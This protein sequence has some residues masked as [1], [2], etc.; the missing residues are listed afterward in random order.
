MFAV[1]EEAQNPETQQDSQVTS[2]GGEQGL[3]S[4]QGEELLSLKHV[5]DDIRGG[6]NGQALLL[7]CQEQGCSVQPQLLVNVEECMWPETTNHKLEVAQAAWVWVLM[8]PLPNSSVP[9]AGHPTH[10]ASAGGGQR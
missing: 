5:T 9:Q 4:R 2:N 8:L 3:T 7:L 10:P 1:R 6:E